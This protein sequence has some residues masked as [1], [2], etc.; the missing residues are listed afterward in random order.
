MQ[1]SQCDTDESLPPPEICPAPVHWRVY[2]KWLEAQFKAA[3]YA[4]RVE[5]GYAKQY[6]SA[7]EKI[8]GMRANVA[9]REVATHALRSSPD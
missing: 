1:C 3:D 2:A 8:R 9:V 6:R 5:Q 7:L 4:L